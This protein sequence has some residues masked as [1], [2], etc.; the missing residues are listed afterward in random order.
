[1][2]KSIKA[3]LAQQAAANIQQHRDADYAEEFDAG[4]QH[5]KIRL[6][7]ID[8]S[9]FQP[10]LTFSE[11]TIR[12]LAESI[13]AIGLTQPVTVRA[14]GDR[15]QLI[16]G[17]RRLRAHRLLNRPTIEALVVDV[18]D[19]QSAAMALSENID[20]S[21][22]SDFEI[23]EGMRL[24]EARFP[25]RAHLAKALNLARSELYRYLAFRD[26]PDTAIERLRS[27]PDLIGRRA[28]SDIVQALRETPDAATRLDEA[29]DLIQ[30]GKLEQGR[31]A[32]FLQQPSTKP[33][34]K[35][36]AKPIILTQ[37]KVRIGTIARTPTDLVIKVSHE[38]LPEEKAERLHKF[39][40]EL[41]EEGA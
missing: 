35:A 17:E 32:A 9:P 30:A 33:T 1:M 12:D 14:T 11:E 31:L 26:L 40:R 16:A 22:L 34:S 8:P 15:F 19:G 37:G 28:A 24:L 2:S 18:D 29:L 4:R 13:A 41:L 23:A 38:A 39:L 7:R 6:D 25:K 21:D 27:K 5:T 20:R 10:R 3:Q 36:A